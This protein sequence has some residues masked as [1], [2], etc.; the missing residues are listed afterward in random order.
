MLMNEQAD[1]LARNEID[2]RLLSLGA[3][4]AAVMVAAAVLVPNLAGD[5]SEKGEIQPVVVLEPPRTSGQEALSVGVRGDTL[6]H[7]FEISA[8]DGTRH[9]LSDFRGKAVLLT[10][11]ATW[12]LP[13]TTGRIPSEG[14]LLPD[15]H[16]VSQKYGDRLAIIL[17][18]RGESSGLV[19]SYLSQVPRTD[20]GRGVTFTVNGVDPDD[21]L[22]PMIAH[23][24]GKLGMPASFFIDPNGLITQLHEYRADLKVVDDAVATALASAP[25]G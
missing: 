1:Q 8:G 10:F 23:E 16:V 24:Y 25:G 17:V 5:R 20:R 15:L 13:C 18:N 6:A 4:I 9:R 11:W 3:L 2:F 12:C 22:F 21:T 19:D 14:G 7:D